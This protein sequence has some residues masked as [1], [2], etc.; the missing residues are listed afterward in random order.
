MVEF[1]LQECASFRLKRRI[2]QSKV[3]NHAVEEGYV[4]IQYVDGQP[5]NT[6]PLQNPPDADNIPANATEPICDNDKNSVVDSNKPSSP[7]LRDKKVKDRI[8]RLEQEAMAQAE[9]VPESPKHEPGQSPKAKD[10]Y[11]KVAVVRTNSIGASSVASDDLLTQ[12]EQQLLDNDEPV[13]FEEDKLLLEIDSELDGNVDS[14]VEVNGDVDGSGDAGKMEECNDSSAKSIDKDTAEDGTKADMDSAE[15]LESEHNT[16]GH[17]GARA[18][19]LKKR[20]SDVWTSWQREEEGR[21]A[22]EGEEAAEEGQ[23][24][25]ELDS[26]AISPSTLPVDDCGFPLSILTK[27]SC[28]TRVDDIEDSLTLNMLNYLKDYKRYVH[29]LNHLLDL[30]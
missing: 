12:D 4:D 19:Q 28:V 24:E 2:S 3:T 21:A 22:E 16:V 1:G 8:N 30:T 26:R 23:E 7:G 18:S 5:D 13:N 9:P 27:V 6:E 11:S 10:I 25:E 15:A 14:N 17:I 29:I 20:L